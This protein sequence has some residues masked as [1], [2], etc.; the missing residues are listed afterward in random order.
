MD[1]SKAAVTRPE[2]HTNRGVPVSVV[3]NLGQMV[4][5]KGGWWYNTQKKTDAQGF[6]LVAWDFASACT[7]EKCPVFSRC[8]YLNEWEERDKCR[9]QQQYFLSIIKAFAAAA[10][11]NDGRA[12][13]DEVVKFGYSLLPL[14]GQLFRFKLFELGDGELMTLNA[15]GEVRVNPIFKEI[16]EIIKTIHGVWRDICQTLRP[17]A[18]R[19]A[20]PGLGNDA[21]IDALYCIGEGDGKKGKTVAPDEVSEDGSGMDFDGD[22]E[23]PECDGEGVDIEKYNTAQECRPVTTVG[24]KRKRHALDKVDWTIKEKRRKADAA[25]TPKIRKRKG[26]NKVLSPMQ[27]IRERNAAERAAN[28]EIKEI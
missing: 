26:P 1:R 8:M 15:R 4:L 24:R 7:R 5:E 2:R 18:E 27:K 10:E 14:Y 20:T 11:K 25:K 28:M 6:N 17:V 9:M 13:Q 3:E 21:F 19:S 12:S 22:E 16:R 23:I